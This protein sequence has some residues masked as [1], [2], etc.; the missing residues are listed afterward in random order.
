M[1][2][3]RTHLAGLLA[4]ACLAGAALAAPASTAQPQVSVLAPP[5][6]MPGLNRERG[7]RVYLPPS[8]EEQPARRYPVL[9]MHDGQNLFDATTAYAG[10]WGVDETLNALA[11]AGGPE[12][13]VVGID[14]GRE[15]RN[16]ELSPFAHPRIGAAEGAQ[17]L[18]FIVETV[19]PFIDQRY[20]TRPEPEHTGVMGSSMGGLISHFAIQQHPQVFGRAGVFSP[21]Y[22]VSPQLFDLAARQALAPGARL[23]LYAGGREGG[24]IPQDSQKMFGVLQ[25]GNPSAQLQFSLAPQAGHDEAAWRAEFGRAVQW[26]FGPL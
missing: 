5:L 24:N 9:Y 23:Y 17:Y 4:A 6:P 10:E 14:N 8:Y 20:R 21:S 22:W 16:V 2:T 15:R 3:L 7:L 13:I 11:R 12:V 18:R 19:K 25:A 26:L 1:P